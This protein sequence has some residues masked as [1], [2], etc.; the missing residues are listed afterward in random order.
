MTS[1]MKTLLA[2]PALVLGSSLMIASA[3]TQPPVDELITEEVIS[4]IREFMQK[5][6]VTEAIIAQN[7][8]REGVTEERILELDQAWRQEVESTGEQPLITLALGSPTSTY[9][10]RKQ[11]A[12]KGLYNEIFVMDRYGMNVAQSSITSDFWQGDEAKFQKT[13]PNGSG[14]IFIDEPEFNDEFDIWIVQVNLTISIDGTPI[15]ASTVEVNLTELQRRSGKE[16][17]SND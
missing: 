14:A 5:P 3:T 4:E 9:L 7:K 8:S 13:F 6:I 15:G 10:L 12:S 16:L 2:L 11:A 1:P 17:S